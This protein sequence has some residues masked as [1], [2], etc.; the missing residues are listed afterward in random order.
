MRQPQK[1]KL[2]DL[3]FFSPFLTQKTL[4]FSDQQAHQSY[5]SDFL[6]YLRHPQA[7]CMGFLAEKKYQNS[8]F[9]TDL[10]SEPEPVYL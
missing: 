10:A 6:F 9:V 3:D 2:T 1:V 4:I 5:F 7:R 8:N